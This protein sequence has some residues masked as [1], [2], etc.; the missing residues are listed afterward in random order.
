MIDGNAVENDCESKSRYKFEQ[1][2]LE[3]SSNTSIKKAI[4]EWKIL[5]F[6]PI[7]FSSDKDQCICQKTIGSGYIIRNLTNGKYAIVGSKCAKKFK[8]TAQK[9]TKR[10]LCTLNFGDGKYEKIQNIEDYSDRIKMMFEGMLG[11][12]IEQCDSIESLLGFYDIACDTDEYKAKEKLFVEEMIKKIEAKRMKEEN[13][14]VEIAEVLEA[15]REIKRIEKEE[16]CREM[17]RIEE[18]A[19]K[20]KIQTELKRFEDMKKLQ[21]EEAKKKEAEREKKHKRHEQERQKKESY[22]RLQQKQSLREEEEQKMLVQY[23]ATLSIEELEEFVSSK[24]F[25]KIEERRDKN[26]KI[27]LDKQT[28]HL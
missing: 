10:S 24:R 12:T 9:G 14:R 11:K 23:K 17:K 2:L 4:D 20:L 28:N 13:E 26:F 1:H 5:I 16:A 21:E 3:L 27:W 19:N 6:T 22:Y 15:R 25:L 7:T 8:K 18:E